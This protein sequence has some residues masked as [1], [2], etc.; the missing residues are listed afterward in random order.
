M[1]SADKLIVFLGQTFSGRV[2]D[3]TIL[4]TEFPVKDLWFKDIAALFDLGYQGVQ[5]DYQGEGIRLPH[6]K[7]PKSKKKPDPHLSSEQKQENHALAKLRVFVEHAIGGIKRFRVLVAPYR[8]RKA[9]F[10]DD[11]VVI[12]AG[13]WNLWLL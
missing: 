2:H 6:K 9:D 4:K 10:E 3:Y 1:S 13:L 12:S 8:N 7:P 5:K 11:I